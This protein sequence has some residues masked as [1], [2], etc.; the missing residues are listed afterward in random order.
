MGSVHHLGKFVPN[1]RQLCFPLTP[2][3]KKNTKF[4]WTDEDEDQFKLIKQK[5][6]ETTK[7]SILTP[8]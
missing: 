4:I 3:L 6:A 2:L 5:I 8:T 1:L 7:I